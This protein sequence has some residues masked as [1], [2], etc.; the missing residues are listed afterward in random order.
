MFGIETHFEQ[1]IN[2]FNFQ[3]LNVIYSLSYFNP[4]I[5]FFLIQYFHIHSPSFHLQTE[6]YQPPPKKI[7]STALCSFF[8]LLQKPDFDTF[9]AT[10]CVI[11]CP[12]NLIHKIL[13]LSC[14]RGKQFTDKNIQHL[15]AIK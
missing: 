5:C 13:Y 1:K 3:T 14:R 10:F 12:L 15:C 8:F 11:D 6:L 2:I 4:I 9:P 7:K